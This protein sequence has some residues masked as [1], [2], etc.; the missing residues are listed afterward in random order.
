[1][2]ESKA[3]DTFS[4]IRFSTKANGYVT[5]D[6]SRRLVPSALTV[7]VLECMARDVNEEL[8]GTINSKNHKFNSCT[9]RRSAS[10]TLYV[11]GILI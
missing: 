11:I 7:P 2:L 10:L 8:K 4:F 3:I 6:S 9:H 5:S 1:M